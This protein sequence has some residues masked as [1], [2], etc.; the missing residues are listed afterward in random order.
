MRTRRLILC[1]C[2]ANAHESMT[3]MSKKS[4]AMWRRN[5]GVTCTGLGLLLF[6]A[7]LLPYLS[8]CRRP[9][10]PAPSGANPACARIGVAVENQHLRLCHFWIRLAVW[11][12]VGSLARDCRQR[13]SF[14]LRPDDLGRNVRT[15]RLLVTA[16]SPMRFLPSLTCI[17]LLPIN[18]VVLPDQN[19]HDEVPE[20]PGFR[21]V[22]LSIPGRALIELPRHRLPRKSV[23]LG[24]A[25]FSDGR[26]ERRQI[27]S[28]YFVLFVHIKS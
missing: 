19:L 8:L 23:P 5:L 11:F 12:R 24:P 17:G 22:R 14:H 28:Q 7:A 21:Q 27:Q 4:I 25:H 1:A 26:S 15:L 2:L 13:R 20:Q 16:L 3:I 9:Q 10:Q 6:V 18:A